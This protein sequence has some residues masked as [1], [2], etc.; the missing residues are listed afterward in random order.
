MIKMSITKKQKDYYIEYITCLYNGKTGN[1]LKG[2]VN[3]KKLI[4]NLARARHEIVELVNLNLVSGSSLLTLTYRENMQ[5]YEKANTDFKNFVKR[6]KYNYNLNLKYIRVIELQQ[7]GSIHFHVII[8]NPE[9]LNIPYNDIFNLWGFGAIHVKAID[10][11]DE[12]TA[13]KLGNYLGKYLTKNKDIEINKKIYST[14]R[15]LIRPQKQRIVIEH[16]E[17]IPLYEK[18]LTNNSDMILEVDSTLKKY[19]KSLTNN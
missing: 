9:F 3:D 14:S 15:N 8:F 16:E 17:L 6:L 13:D 18:I 4:T 2:S 19:I 11:I 1:N 12:L 7:R 5:D 10:V